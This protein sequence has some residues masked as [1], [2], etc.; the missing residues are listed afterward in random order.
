MES[1]ISLFAQTP[2]L[3]PIE[4]LMIEAAKQLPA[5]AAL[6]F[7]VMQFLKHIRAAD[8]ARHELEEAR[9]KTL[10]SINKSCHEFQES[11]SDRSDLT[12]GRAAAALE[13]SAEAMGRANAMMAYY[14]SPNEPKHKETS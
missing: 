12:H 7:I 6:I 3:G 4:S 14:K 11:I 9:L 8:E 5:V 13:R 10:E 1:F 2:A